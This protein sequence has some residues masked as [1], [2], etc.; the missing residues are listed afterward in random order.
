MET[1]QEHDGELSGHYTKTDYSDGVI[2]ASGVSN[3]NAMIPDRLVAGSAVTTL[4]R[5]FVYRK[6]DK[7]S[8]AL[9]IIYIPEQFR[10][11]MDGNQLKQM[12]RG[13]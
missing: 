9:A 13:Q 3:P 8:G 2:D 6:D 11:H 4:M 1:N 12:Q 10:M 7:A 5:Q